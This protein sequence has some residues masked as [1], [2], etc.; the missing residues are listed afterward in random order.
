MVD[1]AQIILEQCL[2]VLYQGFEEVYRYGAMDPGA[3][4]YC[5]GRS[6]D[7]LDLRG[8]AGIGGACIREVHYSGRPE[9]QGRQVFR[10]TGA[11]ARGRDIR[12]VLAVL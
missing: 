8:R 1:P 2:Q 3:V 6:D 5:G 11:F 4:F 9:R 10:R 7:T 12:P